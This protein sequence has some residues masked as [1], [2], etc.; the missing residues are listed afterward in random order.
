MYARALRVVPRVAQARFASAS[1]EWLG[2]LKGGKGTM[3]VPSKVSP[4]L[5]VPNMPP[6]RPIYPHALVLSSTSASAALYTVP[7][8]SPQALD[9]SPFTFISR[10][11]KDGNKT[12]PE[13]LIGAAHAGCYSM[14]L[15]AVLEGDKTPAKS[16]KTTAEV[17]PLFFLPPTCVGQGSVTTKKGG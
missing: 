12:N 8:F 4:P 7:F 9:N 17:S 10:F 5:L 3:S 1:A 16:I 14:F 11:E 6:P 2:T 15:G 13:E